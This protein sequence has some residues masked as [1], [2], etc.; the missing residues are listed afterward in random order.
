M[1]QVYVVTLDEEFEKSKLEKGRGPDKKP[2]KKRTNKWAGYKEYAA[3][4]KKKYPNEPAQKWMNEW[5]SRF[6]SDKK[7]MRNF[8]NTIG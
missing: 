3:K 2:R 7:R 8:L 4:M 1:K 6:P 5:T